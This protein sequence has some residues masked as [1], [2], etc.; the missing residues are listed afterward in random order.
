M[1]DITYADY[2]HVKKVYKNFEIKHLGENSDLCVQDDAL[3]LAGGFENFQNIRFKIYEPDPGS[4]VTAPGLTWQAA[5]KRTKVKL[6]LLYDVDLLVIIEKGIR[7]GIWDGTH[8]YAKNNPKYAQ[9]YDKN[10][11][12][13]Y[14]MYWNMNNFYQLAISQNLLLAGFK[15]VGSTFQFNKG[16]TE[17]Y[18]DDSKEGYLLEN[19]GQYLKK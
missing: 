9:N 7:G 15:W 19:H 16:F 2:T 17:N 5:F 6:D 14:L 12:S 4:F 1:E 18:N 10:K 11:E 3:L 13:S 8:W